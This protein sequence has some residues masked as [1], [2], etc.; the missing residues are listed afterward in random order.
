MLRC[1]R[2]TPKSGAECAALPREPM[3]ASLDVG[4]LEHPAARGTELAGRS[5]K[6]TLARRA[7]IVLELPVQPGK[8][9]AVEVSPCLTEI[10]T[11]AGAGLR[12][13]HDRD[14]AGADLLVV[15]QPVCVGNVA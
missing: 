1:C 15:S 5:I 6:E 12:E 7:H 8:V 14:L 2:A 9:H 11:V 13:I 4:R 3:S 10:A